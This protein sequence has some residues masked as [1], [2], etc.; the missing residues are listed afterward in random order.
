[1]NRVSSK[2]LGEI[3]MSLN[4]RD[5]QV[6]ETLRLLRYC[7]TN[8]LQRLFFY[9]AST[10]RAALTAAMKALPAQSRRRRKMKYLCIPQASLTE[11]APCFISSMAEAVLL[12]YLALAV[13]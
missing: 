9:T 5:R 3:E 1:M 2:R 7:K 13:F 8:Q 11:T 10:P 4:E 12:K 6:L